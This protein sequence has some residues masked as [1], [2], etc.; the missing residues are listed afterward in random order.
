MKPVALIAAQLANSSLPRRR[1]ARPVRRLGLDA[2]RLRA[3]RPPLLRGRARPGLLRRDPPPL[4]GVHPWPLSASPAR[5]GAARRSTGRQAFALLRLAARPGAL[6]P[7]GR[8]P[9]R[10]ERAH[11][12]E[13]RPR[14]AAGRSGS[15]EIKREAAAAAERRSSPAARPRSS[16]ETREADR[17]DLHPLRAAAAAGTVKVDAR[18]IWRGWSRCSNELWDTIADAHAADGAAT[19]Q[20]DD[21]P[22]TRP[23]QHSS[24][25]CA[26]ST[27]P[28]RSTASATSSTPTRHATRGGPHEHHAD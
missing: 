27:K 24:R 14:R 26:P 23:A 13:A 22:R 6:L 10:G 2:D 19:P 16:R 20:H 7:G 9:V 8:R 28:V 4:R 17:G 5:I 25:C 11:G 12:R 3:A 21:E 1:R 18:P 15:H